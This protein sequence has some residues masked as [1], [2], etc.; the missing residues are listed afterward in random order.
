M[1][2]N[3]DGCAS[4]AAVAYIWPTT[5]E[6]KRSCEPH[7]RHAANI[8]SALGYTLRATPLVCAACAEANEIVTVPRRGELCCMCR[9]VQS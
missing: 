1:T 9:R 5:G 4:P 6:E 2:C 7:A 3:Q 8:M